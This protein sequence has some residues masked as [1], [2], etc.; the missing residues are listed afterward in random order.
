MEEVDL[1]SNIKVDNFWLEEP[2]TLDDDAEKLIK[3]SEDTEDS[4]PISNAL[5]YKLMH[6][7]KFEDTHFLDVVP[8]SDDADP[9]S[10]DVKNE[11]EKYSQSIPIDSRNEDNSHEKTLEVIGMCSTRSI[12]SPQQEI[13][14][15]LSIYR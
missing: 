2:N 7:V 14:T 13:Q 3:T 5:D 9:L 10:F 8:G 11:D 1:K 15:S 4:P 12:C 6:V